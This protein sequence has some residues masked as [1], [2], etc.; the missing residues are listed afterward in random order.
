M[1]TNR[2]LSS[3]ETNAA[4]EEN[5]KYKGGALYTGN[6][7]PEFPGQVREASIAGKRNN[8]TAVEKE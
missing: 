8:I 3:R 4:G 6:C 2:A 5:V 1:T 7:L